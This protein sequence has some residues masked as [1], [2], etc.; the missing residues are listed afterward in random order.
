MFILSEVNSLNNSINRTRTQALAVYLYWLRYGH[1][2]ETIANFFGLKDFHSVS[3]ICESVRNALSKD[4]VPKHIGPKCLKR[5]EWLTKNTV[6][7]KKCFDLADDVLVFIADGSYIYCE[8]S[9][10]N[11]IQRNLWS[12]QKYRHLVEP[13]VI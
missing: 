7:A 2:Q 1:P 5:D 9:E 3:D 10:N 11:E 12:G 13:F 6:L 8:K 4:F